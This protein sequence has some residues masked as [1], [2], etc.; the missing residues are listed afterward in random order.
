MLNRMIGLT[1][2][3]LKF[4]DMSVEGIEFILKGRNYLYVSMI[5]FSCVKAVTG[6]DPDSLFESGRS[7]AF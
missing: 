3:E 7:C 6:P 4:D 2:I 5:E 1:A